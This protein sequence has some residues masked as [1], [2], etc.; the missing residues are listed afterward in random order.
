MERVSEWMSDRKVDTKG[1]AVRWWRF[2]G[3]GL[4]DLRATFYAPSVPCD[5]TIGDANDQPL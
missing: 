2:V 3:V 1:N 5:I 4:D